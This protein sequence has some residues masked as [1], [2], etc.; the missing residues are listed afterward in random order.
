ML[1]TDLSLVALGAGFYVYNMYIKKKITHKCMKKKKNKQ[2]FWP[3]SMI[4][5]RL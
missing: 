3:W 2:C 1:C 4:K 5:I